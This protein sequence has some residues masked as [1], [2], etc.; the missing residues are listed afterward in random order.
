MRAVFND[1]KDSSSAPK[2][3]SVAFPCIKVSPCLP[4][5]PWTQIHCTQKKDWI[6]HS[7]WLVESSGCKKPFLGYQRE[8]TVYSGCLSNLGTAFV[9]IAWALILQRK[10]HGIASMCLVAFSLFRGWHKNIV[11]VI[12]QLWVMYWKSPVLNPTRN[13]K[14]A[15]TSGDL[16]WACAQIL[17][18]GHGTHK[19]KRF[20][21]SLPLL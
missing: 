11:Q 2:C 12:R 14:E 10:V 17:I 9:S 3:L 15:R 4:A 5:F 13:F 1:L 21:L 19:I 20:L 8:I 16:R 18:R 7:P 6:E